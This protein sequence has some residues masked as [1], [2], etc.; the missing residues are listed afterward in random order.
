MLLREISKDAEEPISDLHFKIS[1]HS[2]PSGFQHSPESTDVQ[3]SSKGI[4]VES[5]EQL[6]K[7]IETEVVNSVIAATV[8]SLNFT[9]YGEEKAQLPSHFEELTD[10]EDK[11]PKE[12]AVI[13][14]NSEVNAATVCKHASYVIIQLLL[15]LLAVLISQTLSNNRSIVPT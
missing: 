4:G 1:Q 10:K 9:T 14:G 7:K 15:L 5:D 8:Q 6:T 11:Y 2:S 12:A 13:L 3:K